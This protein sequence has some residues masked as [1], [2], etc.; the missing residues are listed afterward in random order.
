M[1]AR[2]ASFFRWLGTPVRACR[3]LFP[4]THAGR[5]TLIYIVLALAGPALTAVVM[6]AMQITRE[7]RQWSIFGDMADRVAWSLFVIVCALACFVSIRAIRVGKDGASV[8]GREIEDTEGIKQAVQAPATAA[9]E[10]ADR[11]K[12]E[13]DEATSGDKP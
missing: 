10:V 8:E 1:I 2:C 5:Q 6:W 4:F 13:I 11:V 7:A 12:H 9:Q 3:S